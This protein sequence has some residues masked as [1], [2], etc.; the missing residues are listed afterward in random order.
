MPAH[1][2]SQV[3]GRDSRAHWAAAA[4]AVASDGS[5]QLA[6]LPSLLSSHYVMQ[7]VSAEARAT[8]QPYPYP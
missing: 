6:V 4:A 3:S 8:L 1:R 2:L 7:P 5:N